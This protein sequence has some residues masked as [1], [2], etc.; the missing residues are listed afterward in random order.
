MVKFFLVST[1]DNI[2]TYEYYPEDDRSKECGII[3]LDIISGETTLIKKAEIGFMNYAGHA[4]DR[5]EE[6]FE[7]GKVPESGTVMWY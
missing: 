2:A 5:I 4:M 1:V 3:T 6:Y 7:K